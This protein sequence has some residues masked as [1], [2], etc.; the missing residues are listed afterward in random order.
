[1]LMKLGLPLR[2]VA[3]VQ[4]ALNVSTDFAEAHDR[5]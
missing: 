3:I 4:H 2:E 1:M 5:Q